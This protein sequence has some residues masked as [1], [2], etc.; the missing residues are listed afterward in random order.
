MSD[1]TNCA[2]TRNAISL[3]DSGAGPTPCN[4]QAG[5]IGPYGPVPVLASLSARQVK[6]LGLQTSGISGRVGNTSLRSADLQS[7]LESRLRVLLTGSDLCAVT[8]K[9]WITP[10][11]TC[12]SKPRAQVQIIAGTDC[13]L[14]PTPASR[15]WRSES[16]SPKFYERWAANPKGKTLPMMVA[17][18]ST[19]T[20]SLADKGVRSTTGAIKEATR[21][22][23][24][25][26]AAQAAAAGS[27]DTTERRGTLNPAFVCWLMGYPQEWVNCAP[28]EMPS[29]RA[30]RLRLLQP[31]CKPED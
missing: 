19:P 7:S 2:D 23:H 31:T 13:G 25:D 9:T 14:W 16:A 20:A 4:L 6:E 1:P 26:L 12:L 24:P 8:W 15:D 22:S 5:A 29:I 27:S 21:K 17:L 11:G 18:W 28:S 10:W 3:P 30:Q